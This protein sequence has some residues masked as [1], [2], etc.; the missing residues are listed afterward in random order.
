VPLFLAAQLAKQRFFKR[1]EQR[2]QGTQSAGHRSRRE[3]QLVIGQVPQKAMRR[4]AV[5]ELRQQQVCYVRRSPVTDGVAYPMNG[6][7]E[8]RRAA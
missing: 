8:G 2:R 3:C 1:L 4:L 5:Q 6:E 7:S